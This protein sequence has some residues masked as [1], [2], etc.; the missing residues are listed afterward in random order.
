M[1]THPA[2]VK[3]ETSHAASDSGLLGR[4]RLIGL[5]AVG[6]FGELGPAS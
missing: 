4:F 5:L 3:D 2:S 6:V 1:I